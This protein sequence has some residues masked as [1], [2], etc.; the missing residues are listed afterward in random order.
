M[1]YCF[2]RYRVHGLGAVKSGRR[3]LGIKCPILNNKMSEERSFTTKNKYE[4][5]C[6]DLCV[7]GTQC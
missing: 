7:E 2:R 3:M 1:F 5:I 4:R 6:V